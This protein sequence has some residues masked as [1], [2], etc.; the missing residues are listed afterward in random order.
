MLNRR[1][2]VIISLV[3]LVAAFV[4]GVVHLFALRFAGGDV[5]PEY[6]SLRADPVG[7]KVFFESLHHVTDARARRN[8]RAPQ[9]LPEGRDATLFVF[10]LPSDELQSD[11]QEYRKLDAFV[12]N[13]GRLVVTL[14]PQFAKPRFWGKTTMTNN[15]A[16]KP[17][18]HGEEH[19]VDLT[20]KWGCK[21]EFQPVPR[22]KK[23]EFDPVTVT[24]LLPQQFPAPL[25]W[26]SSLVFTN[27]SFDWTAI[28]ARGTDPVMIERRLG[29][30]TI[31]LAT[32]SYFASNEA[33]QKEREPRLLAWLAGANHDIIFDEAHLGVHESTGIAALARRYNLHGGVFALVALAALFIWKNSLSFVPATDEKSA[34]A[35][36][37]G[38]ESAAGF[39][40]L[41]RRSIP[42]DQL[43]Q[44]CL[45]EWHKSRQ[46]DRRA[47]P[48]KLE[49][50]RAV[51]DNH[52]TAVKPDA[53]E[54]Y[55]QISRILNEK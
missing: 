1:A 23:M 21:L 9:Y 40:N 35:E 33:L 10:G 39:V 20:E 42:S 45:N 19:P 53:V 13:G 17:Q 44:A 51:L 8:F 15:P 46:L 2:P 25:S 50:V 54:T 49:R 3:V 11:E 31:V 12:R 26:H 36:I 4:W 30:G 28:Y 52:N 5:Y 18:G 47:S 48:R 38:R 55:N 34:A 27:L 37:R 16:F 24:A 14:Y 22:G 43:M 7:T 32:D 29:K 6:S 41:L